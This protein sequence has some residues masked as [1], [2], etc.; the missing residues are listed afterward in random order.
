MIVVPTE[1][2][3]RKIEKM[4][5]ADQSGYLWLVEID[6]DAQMA[7]ATEYYFQLTARRLANLLGKAEAL[8]TDPKGDLYY[9]M[10]R[11]GAI[12]RWNSR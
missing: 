7:N 4:F 5:I 2:T 6:L 9:Y 1:I 12:V 11:D 8:A 3:F 10:D